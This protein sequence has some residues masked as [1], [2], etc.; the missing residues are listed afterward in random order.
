VRL[1]HLID[2]HTG[3][4]ITHHLASVSVLHPQCALADAYATALMV[5]GPQKGYDFAVSKDLAALFITSEQD[6]GFAARATPA[7]ER[8][9]GKGTS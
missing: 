1:T 6:A 4:P 5:M 9:V 8:L 2:P 3:H 7:F